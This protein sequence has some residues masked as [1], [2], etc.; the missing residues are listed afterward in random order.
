V[1]T[2]LAQICA[3]I[4]DLP[5]ERVTVT[6]SDTAITPYD[7]GAHAS[8]S[9]YRA[10]QAVVAAAR[11][12]RAKI[13]AYAGEVL[14]ADPADL[15]L[16]GEWLQVRGASRHRIPRAALLRRGLY[17]GR[18]FHGHGQTPKT[19]APTSAAQFAVVDVDTETG[20]VVVR[21]LVAVQDVGRAVNPTVVEGQMQGAAHQ[22]M[23]YALSEELVVDRSTGAVLTGSFMDYRLLTTADGPLVESIFLEYPDPT[24]PFGA[25]GM[26]EPSII[27]TA[28]AI[29]NAILDATGTGVTELPMT[30]ERVFR[31]LRA[32][33]A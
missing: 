23:G 32:A 10:G 17:E 20:Q 14:E 15:E 27:L 16:R 2:T 28:P 3:E 26:A 6:A 31:A 8:R 25:K 9:L 7:S 5:V 21:R 1:K 4:L 18:D 11:D 30:P 13:L 33:E 24:G 12:A 29:C 22:G 19:N